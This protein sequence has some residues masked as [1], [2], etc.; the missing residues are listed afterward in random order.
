MT[1]EEV[2]NEINGKPGNEEIL[3]LY[4]EYCQQEGIWTGLERAAVHL[5]VLQES[6]TKDIEMTRGKFSSIGSRVV[7][8]YQEKYNAQ[9]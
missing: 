8:A 9:R 3:K 1:P 7:Q 2:F 6:M 5:R 4:E